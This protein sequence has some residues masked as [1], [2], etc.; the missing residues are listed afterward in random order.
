MFIA[1]ST[2][3][4]PLEE[5]DALYSA[6]FAWMTPY[7]ASG[8]FLGS[9]PRVPRTG[10]VIVARAES[11]EAFQALLAQ[12]PFVQHGIAHYEIVEF[13]PGPP[14]RR[15]AELDAFLNRPILTNQAAS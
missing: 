10:G 12:D 4:K 13:T 1:I 6:H 5:V 8:A 9:G 7:Y 15:S 2:Y 11:L 14:P 3:L